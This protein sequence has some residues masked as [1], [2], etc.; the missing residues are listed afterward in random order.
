MPWTESVYFWLVHSALVSLAVLLIGSGAVLLCR[1]PARR[2]RII[3]LTLAGC[4]VT[5]W[6]GLIPGYPRL[7][8]GWWNAATVVRPEVSTPSPAK[9]IVGAVVDE[10]GRPV[11]DAQGKFAA[12]VLPG[13]LRIVLLSVPGWRLPPGGVGK[14]YS[15]PE[16]VKEFN[17]PPLEATRSP[18]ASGPASTAKSEPTGQAKR[19]PAPPGLGSPAVA[20]TAALRRIAR[21]PAMPPEGDV[22]RHG[23]PAG[24]RGPVSSR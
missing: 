16:G 20:G 4:L 6:L 11:P 9:T 14:T 17:L 8:V 21:A 19:S 12:I 3:A 7:E 24:T 23:L 15:V 5:S 13:D 2:L 1:Q 22:L 10:A 18:A